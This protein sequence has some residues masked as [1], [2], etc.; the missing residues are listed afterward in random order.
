M[1]LRD[2]RPAIQEYND[3]TIQQTPHLIT[4]RTCVRIRQRNP[5]QVMSLCISTATPP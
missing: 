2:C 1:H 3:T 4:P 5:G